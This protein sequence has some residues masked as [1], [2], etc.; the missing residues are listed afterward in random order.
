MPNSL[1]PDCFSGNRQACRQLYFWAY[2]WPR[3]IQD[4]EM[5]P[6]LIPEP[7]PGPDWDPYALDSTVAAA[8][9][10]PQP[11]HAIRLEAMQTLFDKLEKMTKKLDA[12]IKKLQRG[13]T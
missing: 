10:G 5:P 9:L 3:I 11:E 4:L 12:E 2:L 1:I 8:A 6:R 7:P 13:K